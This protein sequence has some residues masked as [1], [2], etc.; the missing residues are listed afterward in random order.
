MSLTI[1]PLDANKKQ[2]ADT[3][4]ALLAQEGRQLTHAE[5]ALVQ[6]T[7]SHGFLAGVRFVHDDIDAVLGT[8]TTTARKPTAK[9][10]AL[11]RHDGPR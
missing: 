9:P 4:L 3:F 8:D 5:L 2:G 6:R 1:D 11:P 10:G 7:F